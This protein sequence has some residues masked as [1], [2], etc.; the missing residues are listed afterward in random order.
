[1]T[2]Y[3]LATVFLPL[4]LCAVI[5][6]SNSL[7]RCIDCHKEGTWLICD[8]DNTL[9]ESCQ[10]IGTVQWAE[11]LM[12]SLKEGGVPLSKVLEIEQKA[13]LDVQKDIIVR[14]VADDTAAILEQMLQKG[15]PVMAL[16]ARDFQEKSHTEGQLKG[17]GI[18]LKVPGNKSLELYI[19]GQRVLYEKGILYA[20][21]SLKKSEALAAFLEK[22]QEKPQHIIFVDDKLHHVEDIEKLCHSLGISFT[23][24]R[25]SAA[26]ERVK[27]YNPEIARL[28]W[29]MLPLYLSD[30]EALKRLHTLNLLG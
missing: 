28:Q 27:G 15:L 9:I 10:Q 2:W 21:H 24:I 12:K 3:L 1:M 22:W 11:H 30:D 25:F 13:W 20:G 7:K 29:E 18:K 5:I 14:L 6:E 19:K 17:C 4:Y 16:T 23:G 8:I 26:D